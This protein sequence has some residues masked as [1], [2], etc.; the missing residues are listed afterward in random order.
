MRKYNF[1]LGAILPLLMLFSSCSSTKVISSWSASNPPS[2]ALD[3][4]LVLAIMTD[5]EVLDNTERAMAQE[6]KEHQVNAYSAFDLFGPKRFNGLSEQEIVS[7]LKKSGYTSVMIISLLDKDKETRY[8][9]GS[10]YYPAYYP[11]NMHFYRRYWSIY[12][13]V[14]TPGYFT[15][16]TKYILEA[17]LYAINDDD[18]D[19]IYS[20]QTRTYDPS[21]AHHLAKSFSKSITEELHQKGLIR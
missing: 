5:R 13:S 4:V 8:V 11:G 7:T 10:F 18:D 6:L 3:K 14:Y 19:L 12:G 20:A 16:T 15:T 9:P 2:Y 21:N 1:I 17:D